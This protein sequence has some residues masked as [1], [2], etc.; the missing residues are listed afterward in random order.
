MLTAVKAYPCRNFSPG[1]TIGYDDECYIH[2]NPY[3]GEDGRY[4]GIAQYLIAHTAFLIGRYNSPHQPKPAAYTPIGLKITVNDLSS[5]E[6]AQ[7]LRS[8]Y[9]FVK[10]N[11][12]RLGSLWKIVKLCER[13]L[14]L[15]ERKGWQLAR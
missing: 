13:D 2:L 14:K 7:R 9:E 8:G 15:L 1:A 6:I 10:A 4:A 3:L 12:G 11:R 5:E